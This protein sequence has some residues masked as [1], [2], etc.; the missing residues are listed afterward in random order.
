VSST[1]TVSQLAP[2]NRGDHQEVDVD[3]P[4]Q[5]WQAVLPSDW[6]VFSLPN[7]LIRERYTA[8]LAALE[9]LSTR[10]PMSNLEEITE[11]V[12]G[13]GL[14]D[15]LPENELREALDQLARWGFAEPFRD[16]TA[17]VRSYQGVVTRQEAWALTRKGRGVVAAVR[18][19]V[20]DTR[21]ALQLPS[22]LLDSVELTIRG[23]L[24][25]M[26]GDNGILP[27][28]LDDVRTRI[29]ELQRVSA[30][31]YTA[32]AQM[33]QADVTDDALFGDNRD[34]VIEALR[35]FPLEYERGLRRVDAALRDLREIGH[36]QIAE[37]AVAHAGLIDVRD[38]QHWIEDRVRRMSDLEAWFA[39]D[40][41]VHRLVSSA[42]GA[43][44]TLLNAIHRRYS[45]RRRGSDLGLDFHLLARSLHRQPTDAEARRVYAA[46][47]G[48]WPAWHTV[49][50]PTDEDDVAHGT[51]AMAGSHRFQVEVTLREHE[52]QGRSSGRPRK[53][54]DISAQR[55]SAVAEAA[56]ESQR[57]RILA[58]QLITDG[59]VGLDH[60]S[61]LGSEAANILLRAVETALAQ[62]DTDSQRGISR[63]DG[64]DVLVVVRPGPLR[65]RVTVELAEGTLSGPDL[66]LSITAS[67]PTSAEGTQDVQ[68]WS[69][70]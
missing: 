13:V 61:G 34:R 65:R 20:I 56:A 44:Y 53:V 1:L 41:T 51:A 9:E 33:V 25:H 63:A 70:A 7:D 69:V 10:A 47:F 4:R 19:A 32:L 31:F 28:D 46:A 48:D 6:T 21:R 50:G 15:P 18:A 16:H 59:E 35:Q 26:A 30:D 37:A 67:E 24:D 22:R 60:F 5:W 2:L 23:I 62:Y 58:R 12:R 55:Q 57:R 14:H 29:D 38:Q 66:R 64:A 49:A 52:R 42:V 17:P 54:P 45:A 27:M 8:L 68:G 11:Q 40:G 3:Q 39:A 36:R 43:V